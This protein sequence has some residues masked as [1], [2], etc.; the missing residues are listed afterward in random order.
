MTIA[1]VPRT[2]LV[3][4]VDRDVVDI[5][6][7]GSH[8]QWIEERSKTIGA[9]EAASV[10]GL[11][12]YQS[13]FD[14][15][16]EKTGKNAPKEDRLVMRR[17]R[18]LEQMIGAR[19]LEETGRRVFRPASDHQ[20]ARSKRF[21]FLGCTLDFLEEDD[22]HDGPGACDAKS[23][24]VWQAS[25]WDDPTTLPVQY[26]I[27]IQA[28]MT[29]MGWGWGSLAGLL[30]NSWELRVWDADLQADMMQNAV[31][32]LGDFW[33][34]HVEKDTP[35]EDARASDMATIRRLWKP[36]PAVEV[37]IGPEFDELWQEYATHTASLSQLNAD[38]RAA[39]AR[40]DSIKAIIR[41]AAKTAGRV[42]IAGTDH[43]FV[44]SEV[45]R[46]GYEVKPTTVQMVKIEGTK[47]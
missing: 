9:S 30:V 34:N 25:L 38:V 13:A 47:S 21:P 43:A 17:G 18:D 27:Q 33:R 44:F 23:V 20:L 28:Q 4:H 35:P 36:D 2:N 3:A 15:W 41:A 24:G 39:T 37:E 8:D 16:A 19:M 5:V 42:R 6:E 1:E 31:D 40:R 10:L 11:N 14:V 29:V 32:V 46:S 7:C 26:Q 22:A 45:Q 12:P